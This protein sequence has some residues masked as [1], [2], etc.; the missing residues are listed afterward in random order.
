MQFVSVWF[1]FVQNYHNM[2]VGPALVFRDSDL[3]GYLMGVGLSV[4]GLG[5][6]V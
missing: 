6:R 3:R 5:F 2:K 1:C 4:S